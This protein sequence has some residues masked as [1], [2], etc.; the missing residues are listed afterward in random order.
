MIRVHVLT[1]DGRRSS[2]AFNL[3]LRFRRRQLRDAGLDVKLFLDAA[4][5]ALFDA[6]VLFINDNAFG[7][8]WPGLDGPV[9]ELL[10]QARK[11][12]GRIVWFDTS[13]SSGT[14]QFE[15]VPHVDLYCKALILADRTAYLTE[16]Y[17]GRIYTD[18]YHRTAGVTDAGEDRARLRRFAPA[19]HDLPRMRVS[20]NAALGD[21]GPRTR[22]HRRLVRFLPAFNNYA[23]RFEPPGVEKT[24]GVAC[25]LGLHHSRATVLHHRKAVR[26]ILEREF[27]IDTRPVARSDYLE[28]LRAARVGVS[29]FGY[30][31]VCFRD[32][33]IVLAG[34]ALIKP[35]MSHLETWP[36]L[37][38][39]G[40]TYAAHRWDFSDLS[41]VLEDLLTNGRWR[42]LAEGAQKVYRR[43]LFERD[44]HTEFCERVAAIV[45][46]AT[47]QGADRRDARTA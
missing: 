32:F 30:G 24:L 41:S 28:E 25:R 27:G 42:D 12:T 8:C 45:R 26:D 18:Y 34:A 44:G 38:T 46:D 1:E 19:P 5:P 14:T 4:N 11:R 36:L 16:H 40:S 47:S 9:E 35:D 13:D 6:D 37:Y 2:K 43:Y 33:E 7:P 39:Q 15:V 20:W 17:G 29:P 3:P 22:M 31:E 23:S 10:E 21:Y